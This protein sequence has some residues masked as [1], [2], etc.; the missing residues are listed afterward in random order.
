MS[1]Q[2]TFRGAEQ[3]VS[4]SLPLHRSTGVLNLGRPFALALAG[5][6]LVWLSHDDI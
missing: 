1:T 3:L 4:N 6:R 2:L 5:W